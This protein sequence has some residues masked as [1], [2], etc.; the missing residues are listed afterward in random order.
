MRV[1]VTG[2]AGYIGSVC[3]D[4]LLAHGHEVVVLDNLSTGFKD[5]VNPAAKLVVT[6]LSNRKLVFETVKRSKPEAVIHFAALV[7]VDESMTHPE[8]YFEHN[9]VFAKN[10]LD[11]CWQTGVQRFVFSSTAA[12]YGI[13]IEAPITEKHPQHPINPYGESKLMFEK[14]LKWYQEVHGMK[15]L[16]FRYFNASGATPARG[17]KHKVMSHL[18]PNVLKVAAGQRNSCNVFGDDFETPDG[19]GVRDYIHISDL[20]AAHIKGIES[21]IEGAFNLGAGRGY[22]VMEVIKACQKVTGN[23]VP[24][25]VM[26]RRQG[27]PGVVVAD[28]RLAQKVLSWRPE[29]SSLDNIIQSAWDWHKQ[30]DIE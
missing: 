26:P 9:T 30:S 22:S 11:A 25:E 28:S 21:D 7:R 8:L 19:T 3:V 17:Q 23:S 14:M 24:I 15:T 13:P 18:I 6:C 4:D 10:L 2:G 27:D 12:T 1:L 5:S 20:S 16:I 29:H